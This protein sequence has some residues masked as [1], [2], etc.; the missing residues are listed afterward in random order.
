HKGRGLV[1]KDTI[2]EFQIAHI[3]EDA[4]PF[5][6]IREESLRMQNEWQG[7]TANKIPI[8]PDQVDEDFLSEY[9]KPNQGLNL[10]IGVEKNSLNVHYY[11][12]DKN[13][14]QMILSAE[15]DHEPFALDL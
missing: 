14:I 9:V 15:N 7:K 1:K 2:Y 12:L 6:F 13:Y 10:P 8:L 4:V 3:T 5:Q 11:P